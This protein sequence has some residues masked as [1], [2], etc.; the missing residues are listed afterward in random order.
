MLEKDFWRRY[1]KVYDVLNLVV[2][3]QE[4]LQG[5]IKETDIREGDLVLDAGGG[6]GNLALILEKQGAKV[7]NLDFSQE[8]LEIHKKKNPHGQMILHNLTQKLPFPDNKFDKVISNNTLYN[9][10]REKRL[11]TMLELKRVLKPKGKIVL[12]NI[13]KGFRP[14]KIYITAIK[15]NIKRYGIL[16][17]IK[18][19]FKMIVPTIKMFYYNF[20]I[21]KEHKFNKNNL[22]DFNE[23]KELLNKTGFKNISETKLVYASQG[24]LNGA[25]KI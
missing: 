8:A 5:I 11:E 22:F 17:T 4:L 9:L 15:E 7:I 6:T 16:N 18:L 1:F 14:I 10:P 21:Q 2:P 19:V 3:Y 25:T 23:Q 12:S 13:H 24:I 20:I